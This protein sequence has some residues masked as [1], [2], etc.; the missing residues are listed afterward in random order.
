MPKLTAVLIVAALAAA[1]IQAA[2]GGWQSLFNGTDVTGWRGF[3]GAAVPSRWRVDDRALTLDDEGGHGDLVSVDTYGDFEL[4]LDW[5]IAPGG[6]SGIFY[7]V[8]EPADAPQ[9]YST[10][11]EYQLLD[12]ARHADG[13]LPSHRAGALYDLI[14]PSAP[15]ANPPGRWNRAR[16]IVRRGKIEH[17]LNGRKVMATTY[18]DSAWRAMVA[19]SKFRTMPGFAATPRGHIALQDHGDRVWFR[20]I[21]IR[22]L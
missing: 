21:R 18:G 7:F 8:Q 10:G 14:P 22:R 12:D 2:P 1:P 20:A 17:W 11:A 5:K 4:E 9:T 6:N 13:K 3:K 15:A 19:G 16:V